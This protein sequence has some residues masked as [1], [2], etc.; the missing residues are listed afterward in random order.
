M[1]RLHRLLLTLAIAALLVVGT[2][3]TALAGLSFNGI[4]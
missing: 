1:T 4:D 3:G 2:A